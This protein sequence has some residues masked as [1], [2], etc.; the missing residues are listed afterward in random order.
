[1]LKR[2]GSLRFFEHVR[3]RRGGKARVQDWADRS[4]V[5]PRLGGGCHC[6][7]DTIG[8]LES[9]GFQVDSRLDVEVGPSWAITN[10]HVLGR[11]SLPPGL[12]RRA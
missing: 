7:R 9:A 4:G 12:L 10:P 1:V 5:W 6:S 11:A 3:S 2:G 8:A